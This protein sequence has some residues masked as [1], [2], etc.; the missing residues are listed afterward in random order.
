MIPIWIAGGGEKLTLNVA[1]RYA[2]YTNFGYTFDEF[3]QKSEILA[4][5]CK[6]VGRDFGEIVRTTNFNILIGETEADVVERTAAFKSHFAPI[7][8]ED[9]VDEAF[10]RTYVGGG[11]IAGTSEQIVERLQEWEAA[12]LG[13]AIV[14]FQE[15]ATDRRGLE[16]FAKQV[17]PHLT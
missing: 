9:K 6:D 17:M 2:D 13:Y 10:A 1:A 12:G 3:R 15:A 14:Y 4:G 5:H 8:G 11:G 7:I 16:L